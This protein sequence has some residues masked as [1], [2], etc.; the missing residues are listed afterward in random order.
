[1]QI[2]ALISTHRFTIILGKNG[3]GKS[4]LLRSLDR[5]DPAVKY[6]TPERGGTLK[7]EPSI[8]NNIQQNINWLSD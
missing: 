5:N 8:D 4:T 7:Y 2:Q 3:S 6:I 1:M